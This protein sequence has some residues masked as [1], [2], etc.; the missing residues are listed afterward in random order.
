[1]GVRWV[2]VCLSVRLSRLFRHYNFIF[3]LFL[4]VIFHNYLFTFL[5]IYI[6]Q[7]ICIYPFYIFMFLSISSIYPLPPFPFPNQ[8]TQTFITT[9][10]YIIIPHY[11]TPSVFPHLKLPPLHNYIPFTITSLAS[12]I[13]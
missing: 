8:H 7:S 3:C 10:L 2:S 13:S 11:E 9:T 6:S 1:M 4:L 5:S 12:L